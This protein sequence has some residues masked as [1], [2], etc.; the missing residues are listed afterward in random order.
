MAH[1]PGTR[2]RGKTAIIVAL[3]ILLVGAFCVA[4]C[5]GPAADIGDQGG[6]TAPE[7]TVG[8]ITVSGAWVRAG[9]TERPTGGYMVIR[10]AGAADDRLVRVRCDAAGTAEVHQTVTEGGEAAMLPLAEG[11]VV[12]S[13]GEV[14]LKPGGFHVMLM[15]LRRD[16]VAGETVPLTLEFEVGGEVVVEAEVRP[17]TAV[18][19]DSGG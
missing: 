18:D 4:G 17:V 14:E 12:P 9:T 8:D 15:A 11:L 3:G 19:G 10:N 16:L 6:A 7:A 2:R 1:Q 13:G 5:G